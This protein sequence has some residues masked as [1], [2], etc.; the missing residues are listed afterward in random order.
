MPINC[1]TDTH[2]GQLYNLSDADLAQQ[3][4]AAG[5][6]D[7]V[8]LTNLQKMLGLAAGEG[9]FLGTTGDPPARGGIRRPGDP[10]GKPDGPRIYADAV[11]PMVG[12]GEAL[13]PPSRYFGRMLHSAKAAVREIGRV[14]LEMVRLA[15][16]SRETFE[17]VTTL[18]DQ[19]LT[20]VKRILSKK[21]LRELPGLL[22]EYAMPA[23][24]P[25][26]VSKPLRAAFTMMRGAYR[27]DWQDLGKVDR[28]RLS[29][30]RRDILDAALASYPQHEY[31]WDGPAPDWEHQPANRQNI[32]AALARIQQEPERA[33]YVNWDVNDPPTTRAEWEN[34]VEELKAV[35]A[36]VQS[37][38]FMDSPDLQRI[39]DM[40]QGRGGIVKYFHHVF[41]GD[42]VVQ[43]GELTRRFV[44]RQEAI[45]YA[46]QLIE[47]GDVTE[48][49]YVTREAFVPEAHLFLSRGQYQ[50]LL[51]RLSDELEAEVGEVNKVLQRTGKVKPRPRPKFFAHLMQRKA[52]L[53]TYEDD[54]IEAYRIYGFRLAKKLAYDPFRTAAAQV[55]EAMPFEG[56]WREWANTYAEQIQG[57]PTRWV[58][59]VDNTLMRLSGGRTG[60][61]AMQR[62]AGRWQAL[63]S[64]W[65]LGLSLISAVINLTQI[66]IN[67]VPRFK[68]NGE[69]WVW[70]GLEAMVRFSP[71]DRAVLD[72]AGVALHHPKYMVGDAMPAS[73]KLNDLAWYHPLYF[74]N[75]AEKINRAVTALGRYYQQREEAGK[76]VQDAMNEAREFTYDTHFDYSITDVPGIMRNPIWRAFLQFKTFP[77]NQLFFAEDI[78][79]W[80]NARQKA[81]FMTYL[82]AFGGL[83][84]LA[85]G[86]PLFALNYLL[87]LTGLFRDDDDEKQTPFA[88]LWDHLDP[89]TSA[90][91]A[92][93]KYGLMG[94]FGVDVATRV[95]FGG[96]REFDSTLPGGKVKD[97]AKLLKSDD[98]IEREAAYRRLVPSVARRIWDMAKVEQTGEIRDSYGNL[99]KEDA[100]LR[101]RI[102]AALG[103]RTVEMSERSE[104]MREERV[105]ER[106]YAGDRETYLQR[107]AK[108]L[109]RNDLEG[110]R[111]IIQEARGEG[112]M[113][114]M[115]D[116]VAHRKRRDQTDLERRIRGTPRDLREQLFTEE[117]L[118]EYA[119]NG[120]GGPPR[121]PAPPRP[122]SPPRP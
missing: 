14:G 83:T 61:F 57:V 81:K 45:G 88:E 94:A 63:M 54:F 28:I 24:L 113:I 91:A 18:V 77:I 20:E 42:W 55:A 122:P 92:M 105:V 34:L 75:G 1:I 62:A 52:N 102:T 106:R 89:A 115:R 99:V 78:M 60:P 107:G 116:V 56:G 49:L 26:S 31:P 120:A 67:V 100:D 8:T 84:V 16:R 118:R 39:F 21:E 19:R 10:P 74:F 112:V 96:P 104:R 29:Q 72:A 35:K 58:E 59:R 27:S 15:Q 17:R 85:T 95:G 69:K 12:I 44:D 33:E 71:E 4:M 93:L 6:V 73:H 5:E 36:R 32:L 79:R 65:H 46:R 37:P 76:G 53:Q 110:A 40:L 50:R 68:K 11:P 9:G 117:E 48:D 13:I 82:M 30:A 119:P 87:G 22:E 66:P 114:D 43:A 80:G 64:W 86:T 111:Q 38:V 2:G 47:R 103:V 23:D 121:P 108:A 98:P 109:R 101:D 7:D 3:A 51:R 41:K 70:R 97:I 90:L 25:K